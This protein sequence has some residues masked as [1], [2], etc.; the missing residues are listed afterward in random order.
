MWNETT[1]PV[2][3]CPLC[4]NEILPIRFNTVNQIPPIGFT[5]VNTIQSIEFNTVNPIYI[6]IQPVQEPDFNNSRSRIICG[7][8]ICMGL[9]GITIVLL[10]YPRD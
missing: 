3:K 4:R 7:L 8:F 2:I 1:S 5:T 9:L 10:L 6:Y